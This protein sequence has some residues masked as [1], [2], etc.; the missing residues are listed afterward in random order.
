MYKP[1]VGQGF[2]SSQIISQYIVQTK[3]W[4]KRN[5]TYT[6]DFFCTCT[7]QLEIKENFARTVILVV[8]FLMNCYQ[9]Q[10]AIEMAII[11]LYVTKC[12]FSAQ[13]KAV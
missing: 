5:T 11:L 10:V 13:S 2:V 8:T 9:P 7:I 12:N 1:D 3:Q 4:E 6:K